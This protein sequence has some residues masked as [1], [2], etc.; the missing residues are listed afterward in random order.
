[1]DLVIKNVQGDYIKYF[2]QCLSYLIPEIWRFLFSQIHPD[3]NGGEN[4]DK[5]TLV[6]ILKIWELFF[7]KELIDEI[8][9]KME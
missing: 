3:Q 5:V 2:K 1:M 7:S 8:R 4:R 6:K 9:G